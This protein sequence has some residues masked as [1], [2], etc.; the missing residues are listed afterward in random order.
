LASQ[1]VS[2]ETLYRMQVQLC[3]VAALTNCLKDACDGFVAEQIRAKNLDKECGAKI[4]LFENVHDQRNAEATGAKSPEDGEI[5]GDGL[6][7]WVSPGAAQRRFGINRN[8]NAH[9]SA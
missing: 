3:I 5:E 2:V 4:M 6:P 7:L 9:E 1:E 8:V